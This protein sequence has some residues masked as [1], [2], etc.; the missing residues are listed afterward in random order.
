GKDLI[1]AAVHAGSG[2]RDGPFIAVNLGAVPA[3][4]MSSELFGFKEGTFT[5]AKFTSKGHFARA[6]GGTLFLNEIGSMPFE[7][8]ATLLQFLDTK[9]VASLGGAQVPVNA[10]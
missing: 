2:R 7:S 10:R 8:Q 1:A 6:A 3:A 4:L 5:G 9:V